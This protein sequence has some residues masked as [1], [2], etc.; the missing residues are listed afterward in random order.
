MFAFSRHWIIENRIMLLQLAMQTLPHCQWLNF[1]EECAQDTCG[2]TRICCTGVSILSCQWERI[3]WSSCRCMMSNIRA[4]IR[5]PSN[6]AI[7]MQMH[8]RFRMSSCMRG[9]TWCAH[10]SFVL[11]FKYG[12]DTHIQLVLLLSRCGGCT[13]LVFRE[14]QIHGD[15]Q[16]QSRLGIF[17][18]EVVHTSTRNVLYNNNK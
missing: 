9:H 12:C 16:D 14:L 5:Y 11:L 4:W 2:H 18:H 7:P 8:S 15:V 3:Q 6:H 1:G 13:T 17:W 10:Y